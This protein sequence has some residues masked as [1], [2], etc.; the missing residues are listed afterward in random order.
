[1]RDH[2]VLSFGDGVASGGVAR[3]EASVDS[4]ET[5]GE[6]LWRAKPFGE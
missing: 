4:R 5:R 6:I 1:V 2:V 3:G